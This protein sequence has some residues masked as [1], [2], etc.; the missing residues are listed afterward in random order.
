MQN[1]D[2]A[3]DREFLEMLAELERADAELER[4]APRPGR[5]PTGS[6]RR[7][8][9]SARERK[10]KERLEARRDARDARRNAMVDAF[11]R[12]AASL[13]REVMDQFEASRVHPVV[14]LAE[15]DADR[16]LDEID[17]ELATGLLGGPLTKREKLALQAWR[18]DQVGRPVTGPPR[19]HPVSRYGEPWAQRLKKQFRAESRNSPDDGP[20]GEIRDEWIGFIA[21]LQKALTR[22]QSQRKRV[23]LKPKDDFEPK[24]GKAWLE[25][26]Y[27]RKHNQR[28]FE[29][30]FRW[31]DVARALSAVREV[32]VT[33]EL[34]VFYLRLLLWHVARKPFALNDLEARTQFPFAQPADWEELRKVGRMWRSTAKR[35]AAAEARAQ[36][37]RKWRRKRRS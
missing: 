7:P 28:P 26:H 24:T 30:D 3:L 32:G 9:L 15:Y 10:A 22:G 2:E 4:T 14:L 36:I 29:R 11:N 34:A 37:Q 25:R 1:D 20:W 18:A 12:L 16:R 35:A 5:R 23:R 17:W 6:Q 31:M 19:A 21:K 8:G 13:P 33:E 27:D